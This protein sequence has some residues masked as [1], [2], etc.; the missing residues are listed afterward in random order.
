MGASSQ[1][2][3][4]VHLKII[5]TI[6]EVFLSNISY[7]RRKA[8]YEDGYK[9]VIKLPSFNLAS[10]INKLRN[11]AIELGS[12]DTFLKSWDTLLSNNGCLN[13]QFN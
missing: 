6:L 4:R 7:Y 12:K 9:E 13:I 2:H 3:D 5:L 11:T 1:F 8:F 10:C